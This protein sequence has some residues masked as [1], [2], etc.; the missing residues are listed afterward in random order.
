MSLDIEKIDENNDSISIR[1]SKRAKIPKKIYPI[2]DYVTVCSSP[3]PKVYVTNLSDIKIPKNIE[4]ESMDERWKSAMDEE[5]YALEK[6]NTWEIVNVSNNKKTV[7]CKWLF[8]I[9]YKPDGN[10]DRFKAR[11]VAKGYTQIY[12]IDYMETF[13]RV[14]K[15]TTIRLF[16]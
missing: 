7:G 3:I 16:H 5:I 1:Q 13:S 11:L 10:I 15:M 2:E 14:A 6:N 9:K 8:N 12:G 4:E